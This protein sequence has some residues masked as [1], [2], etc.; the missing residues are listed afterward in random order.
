MPPKKPNKPA[1]LPVKEWT[2]PITL[3]MRG[4]VTVKARTEDEA[5]RAASGGDFGP[6]SDGGEIVDWGDIGTPRECG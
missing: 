4:E 6:I 2:V 5:Y 3:K 1:E